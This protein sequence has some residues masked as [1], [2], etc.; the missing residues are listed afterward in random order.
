MTNVGDLE[1]SDWK[2]L[3]Y[4]LIK[5]NGEEQM[6]K[7]LLKWVKDTMLWVHDDEDRETEALEMHTLRIFDNVEWT[8]YEAFNRKYR[9]ELFASAEETNLPNERSLHDNECE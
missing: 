6:Q 7:W 2:K 3:V 8:D 4:M 5:R 9:P 1:L